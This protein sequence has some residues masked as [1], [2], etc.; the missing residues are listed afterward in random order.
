MCGKRCERHVLYA[1]WYPGE[2]G[3]CCNPAHQRTATSILVG[4]KTNATLPS[5]LPEL[6]SSIGTYPFSF[7]FD[8]SDPDS[9]KSVWMSYKE[10]MCLANMKGGDVEEE[11]TDATRST[12]SVGA[13]ASSSRAERGMLLSLSVITSLL[14]SSW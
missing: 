9:I 10:K 6:D 12:S 3:S 11:T 1:D 5:E 7:N 13:A 14:P 8:S 4:L 2:G